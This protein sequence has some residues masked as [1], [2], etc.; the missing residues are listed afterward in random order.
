MFAHDGRCWAWLGAAVLLFA[1]G[2]R[3]YEPAPLDPAHMLA[4]IESARH[5]AAPAQRLPLAEAVSLARTRSPALM[6]AR[7]S[8]ESARSLA[9]IDTPLPN[10][11]IGVGALLLSGPDITGDTKWGAE[12]AVG[13]LLDLA[14]ARGA[15][16]DVR[17]A[18][19]T[20]ASVSL[21][22]RERETYL[23]VRRAFALL[24]TAR[25]RSEALAEAARAAD[26]SLSVTHRLVE[27][28]LATAL[29]VRD[30]EVATHRARA[31]L[32]AGREEEDEA[33]ATIA[34]LTG[35]AASAFPDVEAPQIPASAPGRE[36]LLAGLLRDHPALAERRAAYD[37]TEAA[38]RQEITAQF[39]GLDVEPSGEREEDA[40]KWGLGFGIEVPLF[41]RNQLGIA[42]A[43]GRR[44]E[45]RAAFEAA[46]SRQVAAIDAALTRLA[47]RAER[48][49]L[50][51]DQA[52]PAARATLDLADRALRGGAADALRYMTVARTEREVRL[53][54]LDAEESVLEAWCDLEAACG[55]PLLRFA[56]TNVNAAPLPAAAPEGDQ[57]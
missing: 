36:Q 57:R 49:T 41:D 24:H 16:H 18:E 39:P 31:D 42:A 35:L 29:D 7:E 33:R 30:M 11:T 21:A 28:A 55:S 38:L 1:T 50:L 22:G 2:C 48:L 44:N 34:G 4:E 13:W 52:E 14:G 40:E 43:E 37:V 8:A 6:T 46:L 54:R 5:V 3:S 10:P 12:G 20:A 25:R 53:D 27:A 32:L 17:S 47:H 45:A 23:D 51:R 56:S 26:S 9:A 15:A 19:A